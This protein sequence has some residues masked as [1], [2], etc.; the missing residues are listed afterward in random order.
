MEMDKAIIGVAGFVAGGV[1]VNT[2]SS[3]LWLSL[4]PPL[5]RL[6]KIAQTKWKDQSRE[7]ALDGMAV[8]LMTQR[9]PHREIAGLILG[10]M[11]SL[12]PYFSIAMIFFGRLYKGGGHPPLPDRIDDAYS[13]GLMLVAG[14]MVNTVMVRRA[15]LLMKPKAEAKRLLKTLARHDVNEGDAWAEAER[16]YQ[17]QVLDRD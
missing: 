9:Q 7:R 11:L 6:K 13:F 5:R 12:F 16:R 2:F 4:T 10:L 17:A 3:L 14:L 1:A 8:L 15:S